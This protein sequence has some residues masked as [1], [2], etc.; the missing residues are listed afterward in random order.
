M[1]ETPDEHALKKLAAEVQE[2]VA[3][4]GAMGFFKP[5]GATNPWS[6]AFKGTEVERATQIAALLFPVAKQENGK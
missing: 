5:E 1:T 4:L 2:T 3:E 6:R